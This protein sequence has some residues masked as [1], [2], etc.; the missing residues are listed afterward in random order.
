MKTFKQHITE[1]TVLIDLIN[2]HDDPFSFLSA[3]MEMMSN[4][5]LKLKKRGASNVR[6]LVSAWNK[7]KKKKIKI[8]EALEHCI[9]E[10]VLDFFRRKRIDLRGWKAK[11]HH[12][13]HPDVPQANQNATI[14]FAVNPKTGE[15][16]FIAFGKL[17]GAEITKLIKIHG[18]RK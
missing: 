1:S 16:E 8:D 11:I 2:K 13:K 14:I 4:G 9:D 12:G 6:E 7:K 17:S 15:E 3:A 10:G 18:L 5:T